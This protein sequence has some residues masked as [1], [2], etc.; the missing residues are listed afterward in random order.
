MATRDDIAPSVVWLRQ[1]RGTRGPEPSHDREVIVRVAIEIAD[2]EGIDA[3]SM[4]RLAAAIG[5]GTS[6]LYRYFSRKDDLLNLMID[7]A[8][9]PGDY[10]PSG[11]WRTDFSAIGR[12]T[13]ET[14][15]AHRWMVTALA[16]RPTLGPNRLRRME[17]ALGLLEDHGLSARERLIVI[18]TL[19]SYVRGFVASEIADDMAIDAS[20][21]SVEQW[22]ADQSAYVASIT[23]SGV[24]PRTTALFEESSEI[25]G[26]T[27]QDQGFAAGLDLILDGIAA[28]LTR[29]SVGSAS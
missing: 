14:F 9:G 24:Y 25:A 10:I 13:R 18:D 3:V 15:L 1:A 23:G 5:S 2:R 22:R 6:S 4:R 16:G 27:L 17:A 7:G 19:I 29:L 12:A 20:G 26:H 21:L 28:K 8:L 11:D